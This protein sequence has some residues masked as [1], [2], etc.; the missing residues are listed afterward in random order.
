MGK[1]L[2][3]KPKNFGGNPEGATQC[4]SSLRVP[5]AKIHQLFGLLFQKSSAAAAHNKSEQMAQQRKRE[6]ARFV[7]YHIKLFDTRLERSKE[8]ISCGN[9]EDVIRYDS[10]LGFPLLSFIN[11][12]VCFSEVLGCGAG[13]CSQQ[14]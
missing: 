1:S 3:E 4:D 11:C 13:G 6:S 9:P 14:V 12:C 5:L 10:L 8:P 7:G 2:L